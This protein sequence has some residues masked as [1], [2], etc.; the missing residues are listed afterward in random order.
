MWLKVIVLYLYFIEGPST[1]VL[2]TLKPVEYTGKSH[3]RNINV[4]RFQIEFPTLETRILLD[5]LYNKS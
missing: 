5:G 2:G 4:F 1:S 3:F